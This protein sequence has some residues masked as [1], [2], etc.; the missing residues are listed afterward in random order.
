MNNCEDS[1]RK[2]ERKSQQR[3]KRPENQ[4]EILGLKNAAMKLKKVNLFP[5]VNCN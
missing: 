5:Y 1:C 3:N 2:K 4:M